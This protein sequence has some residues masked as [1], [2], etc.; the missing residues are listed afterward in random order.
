MDRSIIESWW[1][2][3]ISVKYTKESGRNVVN[4]AI[5]LEEILIDS[6][7]IPRLE[8]AKALVNQTDVYTDKSIAR[9]NQ[10]IIATEAIVDIKY[11]TQ[12]EI[13]KA[14][15]LINSAIMD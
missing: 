1:T 15:Q 11:P 2:K 6:Q 13:N 14:T 10:T 8:E 5:N 7:I 3:N 9:L 12:S 4:I